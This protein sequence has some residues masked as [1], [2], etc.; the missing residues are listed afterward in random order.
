MT[1]LGAT[2]VSDK[3]V[4]KLDD[5]SSSFD[6]VSVNFTLRINGTEVFPGSSVSVNISL[7][8]VWQEPLSAY[9]INGSTITFD[10]PPRAGVKFFGAATYYGMVLLLLLS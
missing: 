7:D 3:S 9:S 4:A 1:Y 2:T 5:I 6:G 10:T 8:G